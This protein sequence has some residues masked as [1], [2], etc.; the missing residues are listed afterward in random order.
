[1]FIACL[2]EFF[3]SLLLKPSLIVN[4]ELWSRLLRVFKILR[5]ERGVFNKEA[6]AQL[7][8]GTVA[9]DYRGK[10]IF[11]RL[12]EATKQY[13]SEQGIKILGTAIYKKNTVTQNILIKGGWNI[14]PVLETN[15]TVYFVYN[16]D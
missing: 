3:I 14:V 12:I 11:S 16:L 2:P 13:S 7:I 10:G 9:S 15:E 6:F 5:I 1:M 8:I 4:R